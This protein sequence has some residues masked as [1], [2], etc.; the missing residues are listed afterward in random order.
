MLFSNVLWKTFAPEIAVEL[1]NNRNLKKYVFPNQESFD[2]FSS[3][4]SITPLPIAYKEAKGIFEK[5]GFS[6]F[7]PPLTLVNETIKCVSDTS[8][9]EKFLK[10]DDSLPIFLAF[11]NFKSETPFEVGKFSAFDPFLQFNYLDLTDKSNV[12]FAKYVYNE[13]LQFVQKSVIVQ[14][15]FGT[16]EVKCFEILHRDS[17]LIAPLIVGVT[18]GAIAQLDIFL[19]FPDSN[20]FLYFSPHMDLIQNEGWISVHEFDKLYAK[21]GIKSKKDL[22]LFP[23][24]NPY[25]DTTSFFSKPFFLFSLNFGK[26]NFLNG[27]SGVFS[28]ETSDARCLLCMLNYSAQTG[29]LFRV[30]YA[31]LYF[32]FQDLKYVQVSV[33]RYL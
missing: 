20:F 18:K 3:T 15:Y 14:A 31:T 33:V 25:P 10:S 4:P 26:F 32:W 6:G 24:V 21:T 28:G 11:I 22:T 7:F 5:G 30:I 29:H 8:E 12:L 16:L 1:I 13:I 9:L 17:S 27:E 19:K 2:F 23:N